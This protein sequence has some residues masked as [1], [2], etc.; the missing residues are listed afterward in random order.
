MDRDSRCRV[1]HFFLQ[2]HDDI[3]LPIGQDLIDGVVAVVSQHEAQPAGFDKPFLPD[4]F[5]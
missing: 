4:S 2:V 5:S 1:D 3:L